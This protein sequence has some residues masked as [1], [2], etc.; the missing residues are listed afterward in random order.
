M[1]AAPTNIRGTAGRGAAG[2]LP[3]KL[4]PPQPGSGQLDRAHLVDTMASARTARLILLRAPAGFGKS[5]LLQQY[6][7]RCAR[8]GRATLWLRLD[9]ADN[10]LARFVAHLEAGLRRLPG[11]ALPTGLA[12]DAGPAADEH[13]AHSVIAAIAALEMP[14][15]IVLDDFESIQ[16]AAVLDFVQQ[17]IEA[18]PP[19]GK[20]VIATRTTP[21]F[22][23]GRIRARGQLLE[24][25]PASLR[26]TLPEATAFIRD[27]C[28]LP[29]RDNEIAT[30]YRCT[31]GWVTAIYLATLSLQSRSDR[32][33]FVASFSG[34][35]LELAEFLAQDI[36]AHQDEACRTFLL[37]TSILAQLSA[38]VCEAVTGRPGAREMLD[39]IVRANLFLFPVDDTREWFRFHSLFASFLRHQLHMREPGREAALHLAAARWYL[40]AGRP[41]PAIEH[42]LQAG[43]QDEALDQ[44]A[45]EIDPLLAAGRVR[46]LARWLD[47]TDPD[48]LAQ[49]PRLRVRHAWVLMLNR[50]FADARRVLDDLLA[51]ADDSSDIA[52]DAGTARCVLLAMEDDIV[53]C[54][55]ACL[56]HIG[57]VPPTEAFAFQYLS[58]A[59]ALA[60][61]LVATHRYQDARGVLSRAMQHYQGQPSAMAQSVADCLEGIIDFAQGHLRNAIARFEAAANR[62]W[63]LA[64]GEIGAGRASL[65]SWAMALYEADAL[66]DATRLVKDALPYS[67]GN[68]APDSLIACHVIAARLAYLQGDRDLWR[69]P[70]AE[71]EQL[72][73]Q[74][75]SARAVCS[76]WLE[77][78]RVATIERQFETAAQALAAADLHGGWENIDV[79]GHASDVDTPS[80]ARWRFDIARGACAGPAS[81]L[82]DAIAQAEARQRHR[83]AIK[84]RA[85]RSLA[86]EG[87]G[88]REGALRSLTDTLRAASH[89]GFLRTFLD[90]GP[91]MAALV[92]QWATRH[93]ARAEAMGVDGAFLATLLARLAPDA[94]APPPDATTAAARMPEPLTA[95]EL[96]VLRMLA[97]GHRNRVIAEKLHVSELTIKAHLRK[98]HAKL[99]AASRTEAVAKARALGIAL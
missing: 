38:E 43:R 24:I 4:V 52:I 99:G 81:A 44:I 93:Q 62:Q 59:N 69:R 77:R 10:D 48:R 40:G 86:L 89:E 97:E 6:V 80:V 82:A 2:I 85:L 49:R 63:D 12:D 58:L 1:N 66:A 56:A 20:L 84:L 87:C 96:E 67:K 64:N 53:A 83:R 14:F 60:Y 39:H 95:R 74:A 36:L 19:D 37:E 70:L 72:G 31:E 41:V 94:S 88:D 98:I 92:R 57:R 68:A 17:A 13:L 15:S 79:T 45:L 25:L 7:A 28:G 90:E 23:L 78:A 27:K 8:D 65:G 33:A 47:L 16:S 34:T 71:L 26:F 91:A 22:G 21:D 55:D 3:S 73:R 54:R 46:L 75:G 61:A 11:E 76:A 42:L 51:T 32:A 50:R 30:L 5:T 29:L 35:N 9:P 18:M